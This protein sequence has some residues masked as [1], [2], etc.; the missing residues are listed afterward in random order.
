MLSADGLLDQARRAAALDDYGDM[1][2][3]EGLRVLVMSVND[4]A[5]LTDAREAKLHDEILRVLVNRLRMHADLQQHPEI[6]EEEVLPPV[7]I[8]SLPRTGS[9]KLHR[10][11][12]ST[13]D[14]NAPTF[15]QAYNFAPFPESNGPGVDPRV[16]AAQRY[17]DWTAEVAPAFQRAHPIYVDEADE[18]LP[19]LDAGFNSL[20]RWALF[21]NVPSY[22]KWVLGSDQLAVFRDLR[23]LLRY[24][25]WQHFP[26]TNRR[27]VLK[28]PYLFG[29]EAAFA[30]I[31]PGTDFIVTHRQP[32]ALW[33]S[34]CALASGIG[35][36]YNDGD[37]SQLD[38]PT[39]LQTASQTLK[40][41]LAWRARYP[42]SKVT[43]LRF[44]EIVADEVTVVRKIY[45]F[46]GMEFTG[47]AEA[48]LLAW[49]DRDA[50]RGYARSTAT[51]AEFGMSPEAITEQLSGY[52]ERYGAF[53]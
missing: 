22:V 10:M 11:I 32:V 25:Q 38:G 40:L 1:G 49:L 7:F 26:G 15:W 6:L 37:F 50:K 51:V 43:D 2:F 29:F 18:A 31:F 8:T 17:V 4:E 9:T 16:E 28:T 47:S 35:A 21:L 13:G 34:L 5:G 36:V 44:D 19:L 12:A 41:H 46:L 27:W 42:E 14:F 53:L 45:A 23:G 39:L 20:Y 52:I 24:M 48:N 30:A 33:P 3:A